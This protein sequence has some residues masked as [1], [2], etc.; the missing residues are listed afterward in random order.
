MP[1]S[2]RN[3]KCRRRRLSALTDEG[4]DGSGAAALPDSS[5]KRPPNKRSRVDG[6]LDRAEAS[7]DD[8]DEAYSGLASSGLDDNPE[9]DKLSK[10]TS[11]LRALQ[12]RAAKARGGTTLSK[13]RL[14]YIQ[15][16]GDMAPQKVLGKWIITHSAYIG[17]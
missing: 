10:P 7:L 14:R 17:L 3:D 11:G 5:P 2:T 16:Y 15:R 6:A 9:D 8:G 1:S 4:D 12:E 13:D